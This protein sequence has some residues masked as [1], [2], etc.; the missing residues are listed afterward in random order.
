MCRI[1]AP[2]GAYTGSRVCNAKMVLGRQGDMFVITLSRTSLKKLGLGAMCCA[3]VVC[4]ALLG[5]YISTRTVT[6]AASV[7]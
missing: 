2:G 3:L 4:S 7:N 5:R 1:P 6:A